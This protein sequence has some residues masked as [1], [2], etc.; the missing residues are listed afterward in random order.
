MSEIAATVSDLQ[1]RMVVMESS[2]N[3]ELPMAGILIT[4]GLPVAMVAPRNI[5]EF[6]RAI[7]R[8]SR[9][10]QHQSALLARFGEL[11]QPAPFVPAGKLVDDL[12]QLR[13]RRQEIL[14]MIMLE[15]GRA[16]SMSPALDKDLLAHIQFLEKSLTVVDSLFSRKV[17]ESPVWH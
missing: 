4:L 17:R 9:V 3:L 16:G 7:G 10:E 1:P 6:A 13:A 14:Q 11:V 15:R 8:I 5:R 12:L 2:G